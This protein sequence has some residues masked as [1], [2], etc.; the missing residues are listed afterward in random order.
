MDEPPSEK[1]VPRLLARAKRVWK[2]FWAWDFA[3]WF[4]GALLLFALVSVFWPQDPP[5]APA[6]PDLR[7]GV[8][9]ACQGRANFI[10]PDCT[11]GY[12]RDGRVCPRCGGK[13]RLD[14]PACEGTGR[15]KSAAGSA[16]ETPPR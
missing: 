1:T 8:C 11:V 15:S 16:G 3:A 2:F 9:A 12:T 10:C 13:G 4:A 7:P 5:T 14:C 6:S